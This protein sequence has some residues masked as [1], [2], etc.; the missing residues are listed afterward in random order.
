MKHLSEVY[1]IDL[2]Q[3]HQSLHAPQSLCEPLDANPACKTVRFRYQCPN[4][5]LWI[6]RNDTQPGRPEAEL[7][8]HID[9]VHGREHRPKHPNGQ[10]TQRISVLTGKT[11]RYHIFVLDSWSSETAEVPLPEITIHLSEAPQTSTWFNKLKWPSYRQTHL[12]IDFETL[13]LYVDLPSAAHV[14]FSPI[15]QLNKKMLNYLEIALVRIRPLLTKYIQDT[16][17]QIS[18]IHGSFM[19]VMKPRD[20]DYL[21]K[22]RI[23]CEHNILAYREALLRTVSLLLR[24]AIHSD[25]IFHSFLPQESYLFQSM[26][27]SQQVAARCLLDSAISLVAAYPQI[28][29]QTADD[30]L[31]I[32]LSDS[33]E[34]VATPVK[35]NAVDKNRGEKDDEKKEEEVDEEDLD[36]EDAEQENADNDSMEETEDDETENVPLEIQALIAQGKLFCNFVFV[37]YILQV[38]KTLMSLEQQAPQA[39]N[40]LILLQ[41]ELY[42]VT[43]TGKPQ[44]GWTTPFQRNT[45]IW[46]AVAKEAKQERRFGGL[47]VSI[48][49]H[50]LRMVNVITGAIHSIDLR[51]WAHAATQTI[52]DFQIAV[53]QLLPD[54]ICIASFPLG[55]LVDDLSSPFG[56]HLQP[57]NQNWLDLWTE[58]CMAALLSPN[59]AHYHIFQPL[60]ISQSA[61]YSWLKHEQELVLSLLAKVLALTSGIGLDDHHLGLLKFSSSSQRNLWLLRN[62]LFVFNNP[63][64]KFKLTDMIPQLFAL[65][66]EVTL[67]L[68]VYLFGLR[69]IGI[70]LLSYSGQTLP[71]YSTHIWA[72]ITPHPQKQQLWVWSGSQIAKHIKTVTFYSIGTSLN[73]R[74]IRHILTRACETKFEALNNAIP[75]S[76]VDQQA[77]HTRLVSITHYGWIA[78]FP[79]LYGL[80]LHQPMGHLALSEIWHAILH[81]GPINESWKDSIELAPLWAARAAYDQAFAYMT[82]ETMNYDVEQFQ[83]QTKYILFTSSKQDQLI[84]LLQPISLKLNPPECHYITTDSVV[85]AGVI[86]ANNQENRNSI[87][88]RSSTTHHFE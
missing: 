27:P 2:D 85:E 35:E 87:S 66:R 77:Q 18:A 86:A 69:P 11:S 75:H 57:G 72:H 78:D 42:W 14:T 58:N 45:A 76:I 74:L 54:G 32:P 37:S 17:E 60:G 63:T 48:N 88:I 46:Y 1:H 25:P 21:G 68:A 80:R 26:P 4:C 24:L 83:E 39:Q 59:E 23:L 36:I 47:K 34:I 33:K 10:W 12:K 41:A 55:S 56:P 64:P 43:Q 81:L 49:F 6:T 9:R 7:F 44:L 28:Q 79:A 70:Q 20:E 8:H 65:P 84:P 38:K 29:S 61:I 16:Q 19:M 71:N 73:L 51:I 3:S 22:F 30:S 15:T 62:G 40:L 31:W 5:K 52:Y 50:E 13:Q 67:H 53:E 82:L